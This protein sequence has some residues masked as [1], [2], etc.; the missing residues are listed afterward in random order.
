VNKPTT[1]FAYSLKKALL[2]CSILP[3]LAL[4]QLVIP[5]QPLSIQPTAKPLIMLGLGRDHRMFYEAYNDASDIDGD[6]SIDIRFKPS[7]TYLGLFNSDYCYT[8]EG[9][10]SPT[11]V[12]DTNARNFSPSGLAAGAN[13]TCTGKWSG[14]WLNYVTTSRIDALRVVLYGGMRE[15]DSNTRTV[16]RRAYIPQDAHS[17]GKEY[18]SLAVDKYLIS[19]YTPL[20]QPTTGNRHFFGNLTAN[21]GVNCDT[22]S[23][24]SDLPPWLSVVTNSPKRVWE[25]SATERPVL[26]DSTHGGTRRNYTI[27]VEVCTTGYTLGCKLYPNNQY[28]PVGILHDFG[29]N[30]SA[31]FGMM[32]GSY[33]S[34][35]S[36]G[37]LRKQISL[38][39]NEVDTNTGIFNNGTQGI[40]YNL[41]QFRIYGFNRARTDNIYDGSVIGN[42]APNQGEFPDWGN[43]VAEMM[44]EA[45]RYLSNRG[46][47]TSEYTG[48]TTVDDVIGL[49]R[50][51]WDNPYKQG[52]ATSTANAPYCARATLLTISDTNISFDSDQ[53]PGVNSNFGS[54]ITAGLSGTH[55]NNNA[56][57]D[58]NASTIADLISANEPGLI[59]SKRFIGQVGAT[60]DGV[61]SAK[62]IGSLS[63]LRGL[64]PEEPSK[65]GSYYAASIAHF[66]KVND[67]NAGLQ[68][69]QT[70]DNFFVALASPLLRIDAK[71]PNG[72]VISVLPTAKSIDGAFS[73][74]SDKGNYQPTNQIV[75]FF[76]ETIAN[77]GPA[78]ADS[79]VNGGRYQAKFRINFEDVEQGN[80]HDMDAIVEYTVSATADNKLRIRVQ[81]LYQAGGVKHRMGYLISGTTSDGMYLVVQDETDDK[82]YFLNV[83]P[84]RTPGYCDV[85]SPPG[86]C[87]RLPFLGGTTTAPAAQSTGIPTSAISEFLFTPSSVPAATYL[88]D[89]LWYAAK[90]GGFDDYNANGIPDIRSE[91]DLNNDGEPDSYFFVQNP[92]KLRQSLYNA[93]N[94]IVQRQGSSSNLAANVSGRVD[95]DSKVYRASYF[96]GKWIGEVE[97]LPITA[98]GLGTAPVWRASEEI[99]PWNSRNLFLQATTG[100]LINMQSTDFTSLPAADRD[101]ISTADVYAYLKG[102]KSRETKSGGTFRDRDNLLGDIIH[103]SPAYDLD[104]RTLYVGS[105]GGFLHAID[106]DT[107]AEKFGLMPKAVVPRVKNIS[108]PA[109]QGAHEYFVDG[110]NLL[111]FK[112]AETNNNYYLYTML[113]R[114][115]KGLLSINPGL[116]A[117][118]PTILWDYSAP[119]TSTTTLTATLSVAE[120]DPDLG[121]M[122]SSGFT[123]LTNNNG[124]G[125][126]ALFAGN[127]YNSVNGKAVLYAFLMN[128][129]GTLNSVRKIDT[130]VAGDNGM[131]GPSG[132]DINADG[133][134]DFVYAG[135]LKGNV[136]K[137]DVRD[138]DPANWQLAYPSKA[139]MFKA[140]NAA[141]IPQPITSPLAV[142]Y[143]N[144]SS[145]NAGSLYI[146]FGTGSY[147]QAGDATNTNVQTWYGIVDDQANFASTSTPVPARASLVARVMSNPINATTGFTIRYAGSDTTNDMA[148]K[149]GWYMD[150]RTP[151]ADGERMITKNTFVPNAVKPALQATSFFPVTNDICRPGGESYVNAIEPTTGAN[152][153][154]DFFLSLPNGTGTVGPI[155]PIVSNPAPLT[156]AQHTN[157]RPSSQKLNIGIATTPL[158]LATGGATSTENAWLLNT[159]IVYGSPNLPTANSDYRRWNDRVAVKTDRLRKDCAGNLI[160]VISGSEGI[161]S[162]GI[163]GCDTSKIQGR[164]SW[165][166]ILKD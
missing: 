15:V 9:D 59:G 33:D 35:L 31:L 34:H 55:I 152:L 154:E 118:V 140:T 148:G 38:F 23:N 51:A 91:W 52:T 114:G 81:P 101:L 137:F 88:K 69:K 113:G 135:D 53:L 64:A 163:K 18:T 104:S 105:N 19:D 46:A 117:T 111:G 63:A 89:P 124:N 151:T 66:A 100:S 150:L 146:T 8:H 158:N 103:S 67:L 129:D 85:A 164:I 16:L 109:Y 138:G 161:D 141:G 156:A 70:I 165:R 22:L 112:L 17:W 12:S 90:W 37:R 36:G 149:R 106:G 115:G 68:G 162:S 122:L 136:W 142:I 7:I 155:G 61:P 127:G 75:D 160:S 134:V 43:P 24:C 11:T 131:A 44:Y 82:S 83:P 123:S 27:R 39:T 6:G 166:E 125:K 79:T 132:Y 126:Y 2:A 40:V 48:S 76:V 54:G 41:N 28:K 108:V 25:W 102:D 95:T 86:D 4:S 58:F 74:S 65:R 57:S 42:R 139:P 72:R 99:P 10:A 13:K 97:A 130:E 92:T 153:K 87:T 20:A 62:T 49:S 30:E 45:V 60:T 14:N 56:F 147:F 73:I 71:L 84:G 94:S 5:S 116:S 128:A 47:A 21:A 93:F 119:T 29:E 1:L 3:T 98:S 145:A 107:G 96:A 159:N 32:S 121:L 26:S 144:F 143:N 78:D 50:P 133:K 110:E 77:S 157:L 80:D 120:M